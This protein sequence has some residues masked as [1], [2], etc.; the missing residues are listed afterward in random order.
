VLGNIPPQIFGVDTNATYNNIKE[1]NKSIYTG[2]IMPTVELFC[3]C[4]TDYFKMAAVGEKIAPDYSNI[5]ALQED[6]K[7]KSESDKA[8]NE[9]YKM[10]YDNGLITKEYWA[11]QIG[12]PTNMITYGTESSGQIESQQGKTNGQNS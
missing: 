12:I 11:T 2:A 8:I 4:L 3:S 5:E 9:N 6:A 7:V 1:A 10:L